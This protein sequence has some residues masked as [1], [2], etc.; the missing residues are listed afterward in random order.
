MKRMGTAEHAF[1]IGVIVASVV[2]A[3]LLNAKVT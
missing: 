1:W 2:V 3:F